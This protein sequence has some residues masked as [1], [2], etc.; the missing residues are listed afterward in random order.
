MK[1]LGAIFVGLIA[2]WIGGKADALRAYRNV[3]DFND[4]KRRDKKLVY[5]VQDVP[6]AKDGWWHKAFRTII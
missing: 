6:L 2:G 1:F 4:R 5:P 3:Y